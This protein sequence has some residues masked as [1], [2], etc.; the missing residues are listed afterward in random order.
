MALTDAE[1]KTLLIL[2][3]GEVAGD[4]LAGNIDL[5]WTRYAAYAPVGA[6]LRDL[7]VKRGLIDIALGVA[8]Q[9]VTFTD[10][11]YGQSAS[12]LAQRLM[13]MRR[14]VEA[15]IAALDA[16]QQG[17]G[18]AA[19]GSLTTVTPE[20]PPTAPPVRP[21]GPDALDPPYIGSPYGRGR[22]SRW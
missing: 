7:Y 19:I 6:D 21:Y 13:E 14:T 4:L 10:G 5:L 20:T 8:R 15:E 2:E 3:V 16:G 1:R 12:H 18:G 22:R 11:D 17:F 9:V